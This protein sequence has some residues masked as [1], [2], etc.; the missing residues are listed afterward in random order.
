MRAVRS[1]V[2]RAAPD[3]RELLL[4]R[5]AAIEVLRTIERESRRAVQAALEA[6]A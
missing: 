4:V 1:L 3:A 5:T 6:R 2:F